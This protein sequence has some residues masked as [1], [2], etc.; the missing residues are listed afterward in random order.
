M[1]PPPNAPDPPRPRRVSR[2]LIAGLAA[3]T[4]VLGVV[5]YL[6]IPGGS[7]APPLPGG[8]RA[9]GPS[10]GY[11]GQVLTPVR[12]AP[13]TVLRDSLGRTVDL[14][15][16]RGR[17]LL[18]TFLYTH[19]PDVCPLIAAKLGAVRARLGTAA[20]RRVALVA[21]SV[22]P[23]GDTPQTAAAFLR[24]H[25]LTGQME[26]LL[27][28]PAQLGRVWAAWNVGSQRDAGRPDLV[29][30]SALVYGITAHGALATVYDPQ[31]D[32]ATVVHDVPLLAAA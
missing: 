10:G 14:A 25:A 30:H 13:A 27:G 28:S 6:V 29:A 17:A 12:P 26:Y 9:G 32:P 15:R 4:V 7:G 8:A 21:I 3:A 23:G 20:A 2:R 24:A 31:F 16:Y 22:D 18:V 1:P 19:C 5:L 11:R